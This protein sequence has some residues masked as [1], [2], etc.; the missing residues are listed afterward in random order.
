[1]NSMGERFISSV[2]EIANSKAWLRIRVTNV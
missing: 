1:M 2:T